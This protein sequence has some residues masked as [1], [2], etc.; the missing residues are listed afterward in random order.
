MVIKALSAEKKKA[1]PIIESK[2]DTLICPFANDRYL[3]QP[4]ELE[5]DEK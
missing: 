4:R 1:A 2:V 5:G 3:Y